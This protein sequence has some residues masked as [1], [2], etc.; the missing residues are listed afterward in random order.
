MKIRN[1]FIL[2][3]FCAIATSCKPEDVD[4]PKVDSS[5]RVILKN[6]SE[7]TISLENKRSETIYELEA[8][9]FA[10]LYHQY[11]SLRYD[12]ALSIADLWNIYGITQIRFDNLVY[13]NINKHHYLD[14]SAY[15]LLPN[16]NIGLSH[17]QYEYTFTE[18]DY[19]Y[20]LENGT[21]ME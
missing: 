16:P 20:V 14:E 2:A 8:G 12:A 3:I 5:I 17:K 15:Q 19:Q 18:A 9:E 7:H 1:L 21:V 10:D 11:L 13:M 6:N 4:D